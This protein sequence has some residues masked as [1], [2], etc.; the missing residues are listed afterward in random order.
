MFFTHAI[1]KEASIILRDAPEMVV[2]RMVGGR[3]E[4]IPLRY[5][6][7]IKE[8]RGVSSVRGRF[9]GYYY[10]PVVGANYT[11]MVAEDDQV[12]KGTIAV[13]KGVSRARLLDEQDEMEFRASRRDDPPSES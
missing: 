9:W 4:L 3:H 10:D 6:E 12:I 13:G 5:M 11:L 2:Q 8:I 7:R 1:K